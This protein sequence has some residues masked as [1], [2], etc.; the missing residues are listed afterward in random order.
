[1]KLSRREVIGSQRTLLISNQLRADLDPLTLKD[2]EIVRKYLFECA[3]KHGVDILTWCI[4]PNSYRIILHTPI[5]LAS[6]KTEQNTPIVKFTKAFQIRIMSWINYCATQYGSI[7]KGRYQASA[8]VTP[9]ESIAA[10]VS[11]DAFPVVANIVDTADEYFFTSYYHAC[12]GD[13][14]A[15]QGI[16]KLMGTPDAPWSQV[17]RRYAKLL[18]QPA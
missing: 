1:M 11:V 14:V 2:R 6:R 7:W 5:G 16:S 9:G 17:K 3:E 15:R 10:A 13:A 12:A 4:M 8:L 18:K